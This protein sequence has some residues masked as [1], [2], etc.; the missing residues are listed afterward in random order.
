MEKIL[1][2]DCYGTLLDTSPLYGFIAQ[3]AAQHGLNPAQAA[4][5]FAAYEDRLMYGEAFVPYN[6]LL[7]NVLSYCDMELNTGIFTP[8]HCEVLALH[9]NFSPFADVL[10]ALAALK[11][12]GWQLALMSNT[13]QSL[14][15]AHLQQLGSCFDFCLTADTAQCY[16]PLLQFFR[17]AEERFS[18]KGK[19]HIHIAKGYW[20]DIVPAAKMGWQKI[21]LNRAKLKSGRAQEQPYATITTL[22]ELPSLLQTAAK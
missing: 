8:L 16:K 7:Q 9:Q 3:T 5:V 19:R 22:A 2:F 10:P 12:Q 13:T 20:W 17:L 18:L 21:W 6:E 15:Q 14:I 1:T 11:A 4:A